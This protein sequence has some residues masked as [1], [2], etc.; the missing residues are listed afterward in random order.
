MMP[1]H[2]MFCKDFFIFHWDLRSKHQ[3]WLRYSLV[4]VRR[5]RNR[6]LIPLTGKCVSQAEYFPI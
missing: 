1:C 3:L 2:D 4:F 5:K 6:N